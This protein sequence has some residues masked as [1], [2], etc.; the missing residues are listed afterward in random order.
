[1]LPKAK[2]EE[3]ALDVG[4]VKLVYVYD[5]TIFLPRRQGHQLM[6]RPLKLVPPWSDEVIMMEVF[7]WTQVDRWTWRSRCCRW[8]R[9]GEDDEQWGWKLPSVGCGIKPWMCVMD[10]AQRLDEVSVQVNHWAIHTCLVLIISMSSF[11]SGLFW[12]IFHHIYWN[13]I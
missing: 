11:F 7:C 12:F 3:N 4:K 10:S 13:F 8:F 1:M 9:V 5:G 6:S 2:E